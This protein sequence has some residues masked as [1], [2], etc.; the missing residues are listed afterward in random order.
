MRDG[1]HVGDAGDFVTTGVQSTHSGFTTRTRTLDVHVE[2]LQAVFQSSL[3]SALGSHLGSE[4]GGLTGAAET[5]TTGGSPG[6]GVTLT[7]SDGHD[8]VIERRVDMG[9]AI[10][11]CLFDFLTSTSSR[12]SHDLFP[13]DSRAQLLADR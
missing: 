1:R 11:H 2:V 12:L 4:R 8:G 6:Q 13:V 3:A 7:V 10:H 5:G 9:D